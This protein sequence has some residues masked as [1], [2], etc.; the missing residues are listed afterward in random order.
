MAISRILENDCA[1][2]PLGVATVGSVIIN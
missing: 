2:L 1:A